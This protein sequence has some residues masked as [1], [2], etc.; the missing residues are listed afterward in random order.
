MG[1]WQQGRPYKGRTLRVQDPHLPGAQQ[2]LI[3]SG[4]NSDEQ[5][6]VKKREL[7]YG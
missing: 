6:A 4:Q 7:S 3:P 1:D 5:F 2:H